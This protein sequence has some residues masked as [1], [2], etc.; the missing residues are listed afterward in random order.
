MP[1]ALII[2][3]AALFARAYYV[4]TEDPVR[5]VIRSARTLLE[6]VAPDLLLWA[7]DGE[8]R[9][10]EK[11]RKP[12][13]PQYAQ[14][15]TAARLDL[16]DRYG[17]EMCVAKEGEA[18]DVIASAAVNERRRGNDVV[19]ATSDG[20]LDYLC[21]TGI[22]VYSLIDKSYKEKDAI[23]KKWGVSKLAHIPLVKAM[24]GDAGD[25]IKGVP[26][27]GKVKATQIY[28]SCVTPNMKFEEAKKWIESA[29]APG[30]REDYAYALEAVILYTN[31]QVP[32]AQP[33]N[34][35]RDY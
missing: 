33:C 28:E 12:K 4:D 15:M 25:G 14:A 9:K 20:D 8:N 1:T 24:V 2:D 26:G 21:V 34:A 16:C 5:S 27:I 10:S 31:C 29:L 32:D 23:L 6:R 18:D 19:I 3:G 11:A 7:W 22:R 30:Q 17:G 13:P 35:P